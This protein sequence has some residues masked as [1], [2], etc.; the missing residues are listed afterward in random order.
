M[1]I[2]A[3]NLGIPGESTRTKIQ[4]QKKIKKRECLET[5][6]VRDALLHLAR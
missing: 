6:Y 3:R 1:N 5:S 4:T 2:P